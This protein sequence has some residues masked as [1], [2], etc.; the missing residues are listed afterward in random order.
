MRRRELGG[1]VGKEPEALRSG[2]PA[3][4]VPVMLQA[5]PRL[6]GRRRMP[7]AASRRAQRSAVRVTTHAGVN[8]DAST[9]GGTARSEGPEVAASRSAQ[10]SAVRVT[11]QA[12][13]RPDAST[14]SGTARLKSQP[15]PEGAEE[16]RAARQGERPGLV[17]L[18]LGGGLQGV[19]HGVDGENQQDECTKK[20]WAVQGHAKLLSLTPR[21]LAGEGRPRER[22]CRLFRKVPHTSLNVHRPWR[23]CPR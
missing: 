22:R 1:T 23:S 8:A 14:G 18:G 7:I 4:M 13:I 5:S 20:A 6:E 9:G 2:P 12:E 19:R 16:R 11:A 3:K 17:R 10:R 15:A 21:E